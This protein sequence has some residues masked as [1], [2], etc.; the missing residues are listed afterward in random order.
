MTK[1]N[2][3]K[4]ELIKQM[5]KNSANSSGANISSTQEIIDRDTARIKRLKWITIL[6][7]ILVITL[8]IVTGIIETTSAHLRPGPDTVLEAAGII[9]LP[10]LIV[11]LQGIILVAILFT[12][13]FYVRSRT[14][15]IKQIHVRLANIEK[16]LKRISEDR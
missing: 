8:F 15:S 2:D 7:W 13:S 16:Q 14:L 6:C 11:I 3:I 1:E 9:I 10:T 5:E 4:D 12:I